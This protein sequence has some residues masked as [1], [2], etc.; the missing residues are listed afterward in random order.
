MRPSTIAGFD[1]HRPLGVGGMGQVWLGSKA[2]VDGI[3]K[4]VAIK[5]VP[6]VA[7]SGRAR[8]RF[9]DEARLSV[10]LRHSNIVQVFDVGID[11][12][13]G[14]IVME[15]VDGIDL[16][17]AVATRAS[18]QPWPHH[19]VGFIIG[20]LLQALDYAHNLHHSQR[21]LGLIH[22][23]I[24]PHNILLSAHGEV[25]LA[26][27]GIARSLIAR[28]T[29]M[30]MAGKW[31]YMAP[32]QLRGDPCGP[33]TD[34]F[35]VG[36]LLHELLDGEPFRGDRSDTRRRNAPAL[37]KPA[38]EPLD[39][40]R[41]W[42]LAHDPAWRPTT[43]RE[44]LT[45]LRSWDGYRES[46]FDLAQLC[47][48][49]RPTTKGTASS[50]ATHDTADGTATQP[51][52]DLESAEA[53]T[54]TAAHPKACRSRLW[55]RTALWTTATALALVASGIGVWQWRQPE[56]FFRGGC[57]F[58][59]NLDGRIDF[60]G[61]VSATREQGSSVDLVILDGRDGHEIRRMPDRGEIQAFICSGPSVT[62]IWLKDG[63]ETWTGADLDRPYSTDTVGSRDGNGVVR[64]DAKFA[65]PRWF[66]QPWT[67]V[68]AS[69]FGAP[70][71]HE[72]DGTPGLVRQ[73]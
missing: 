66:P 23:D 33:P 2:A 22:R 53:T 7:A 44:A 32:E 26:D 17:H 20:E 60:I 35:A 25:K 28:A 51:A 19:V 49:L 40:L 9:L 73:R 4:Q 1:L 48:P 64:V 70:A 65:Q 39:R 21:P 11:G 47:A 29:D 54:R 56:E 30:T 13:V 5:L 46:S 55:R 42:L 27:F 34:L 43:A 62:G 50:D 45:L 57:P 52:T 67:R 58:D 36:V 61:L 31:R 63:S 71:S 14:F 68:G 38:P 18:S 41:H 59:A 15:W 16:A 37:R 6:S 24:S 10:L 12:D 69:G 3:R 8:R 72:G